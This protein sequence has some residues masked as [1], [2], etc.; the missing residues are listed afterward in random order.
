MGTIANMNVKLAMDAADFDRGISQVQAKADGLA[1]GLGK[2]GTG[3]SLAVTAPLV[4]I[5]AM[6]IN[7]AAD[8]EQSMNVMAQVSGATA[9]QMAALQAQALNLGAVTSF[10]AGEAAQAQLELAKAGLDANEVM[11]AAPGV[12]DLAAAGG[13]GLA[14]AA[15]IAANAVNTF[16]LDASST[17]DVAN[18]L[19]AAANA[20]SVE[21]TDL[22]DGMKMAGAVFSSAG[23]SID[24]LNIA[25]ALLGNNGI[26]GSDA[27][28]SLKTAL[29]RLTAPTDQAVE[30][31]HNLGV[32]VYDTQGNMREFPVILADLQQAMYGTNQVTVTSSNLTQEQAQRMEYLKKTISSTQTQLAN[33]ASG[34]AGIGQSGEAS[35][36][37]QNKLRQ[38]LTAAQA[39][40][41]KLATAGSTTSTV[42]KTLTEEERQQA[43]ATIFG[44]DAIRSVSVLMAEGTDGWNE[45]A[46]ALG[47]AGAATDVA[48]ARMSGM[49]GAIEY[50]K[51]SIDSFLIGAALPFLDAIGRM[52]RGLAD[53]ITWV[54]QLPE[55]MRNTAIAVGAAF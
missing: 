26:K 34:I 39:E 10:S 17:T 20:S 19:A 54:G 43:L 48:N 28:T 50:L 33:Y 47:V 14:Q 51:G 24:D 4:G 35:A 15:E 32:Q 11:A 29:M 46:G 6:A 16:G 25:M 2:L 37:A 22:A 52:V 18:M 9:D 31:L 38:T 36:A 45:M 21:V 1:Q 7:S 27:G 49:R 53:A 12:L 5:G 41:D 3:M 40:Y 30:V 23:Q 44:A 8:F 13:L 55:P 42:M